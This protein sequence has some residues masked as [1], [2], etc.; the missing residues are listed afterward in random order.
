MKNRKKISESRL[1]YSIPK[2]KVGISPIQKILLKAPSGFPAAFSGPQHIPIREKQ[3]QVR[4]NISKA[5]SQILE[6]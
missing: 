6:T 1:C 4:D 3:P 2:S 5:P